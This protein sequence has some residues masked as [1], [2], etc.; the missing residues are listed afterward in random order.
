MRA[1]GLLLAIAG[2]LFARQRSISDPIIAVSLKQLQSPAWVER[3][4]A[5]YTIVHAGLETDKASDFPVADGILAIGRASTASRA[6]LVQ[7]LTN[8]LEFE[9]SVMSTNNGPSSEDYSVYYG[10]VIQAV[11]TLRDASSMHALMRC[12]NTGNMATASLAGFGDAALSEAL[13]ILPTS[14]A[15]TRHSLFRLFSLMTEQ[16]NLNNFTNAQSRSS[17][18]RVLLEGVNESNPFSRIAAV[19]GLGRLSS[20]DAVQALNRLAVSDPFTIVTSRNSVQY[21]VR[22]AAVKVLQTVT[23]LQ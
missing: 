12:L 3:S 9:T 11:T 21:P 13:N 17:L 22:D 5:F 15:Q 7:A 1:F 2:G 19:N 4:A 10:D 20:P 6:G 23:K 14:D 8:L 18:L 16:R